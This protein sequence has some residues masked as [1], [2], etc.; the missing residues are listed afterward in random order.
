[1][2]YI[3]V[4]VEC[5]CWQ[6]R[7]QGMQQEIIEIGAVMLDDYGDEVERF[8]SFVKPVCHPLLSPYC[9]ELTNIKQQ[10]VNTAKT[11]DIV[12]EQFIDWIG[13]GYESYVLL[14]WGDFDRFIFEENCRLI[15]RDTTWLKPH[16]DLKAQYQRM[17]R[18]R[19]N[20]G[21]AT[22]LENEQLVFIGEQH[23]ALTDALNTARLFNKFL[24]N[25]D[26]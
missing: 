12:I 13:V 3:V 23:R 24:G 26:L 2:N 19:Q 5:T 7:P 6:V 16:K 25:W 11:F 9:I 15:N 17:R 20:T 10:Q 18:I 4:D 22:A 8:S 1:M 14:S 21:L